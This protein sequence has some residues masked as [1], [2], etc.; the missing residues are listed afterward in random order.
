MLTAAQL[1]ALHTTLKARFNAG[2][3]L[4]K[5]EW[6]Q[7]AGYITSVFP[8]LAGMNRSCCCPGGC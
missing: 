1:A 3:A 7:V 5:E 2:L 8:A 4:T 6:R